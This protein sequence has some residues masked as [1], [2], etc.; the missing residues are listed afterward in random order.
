MIRYADMLKKLGQSAARTPARPRVIKPAAPKPAP[1]PEA[2]LDAGMTLDDRPAVTVAQTPAVEHPQP[3]ADAGGVSDVELGRALSQGRMTPIDTVTEDDPE[4]SPAQPPQDDDIDALFADSPK[5]SSN[6]AAQTIVEPVASLSSEGLAADEPAQD[7]DIDALFADK[8]VEAA[9]EESS[10]TL[11]ETPVPFSEMAEAPNPSPETMGSST[12]T[13]P[14]DEEI[15]ALFSDAPPVV[16]APSTPADTVQAEVP[17]EAPV[18]AP[19]EDTQRQASEAEIDALFSDAPEP[20]TAPAPAAT[21]GKTADNKAARLADHAAST[22]QG[23]ES[24]FAD[25]PAAVQ[26]PAAAPAP[27]A[28]SQPSPSE[29]LSDENLKKKGT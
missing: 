19:V 4:A 8:P 9:P 7:A 26:Q 21:G 6:T 14:S 13:S 22:E 17:A 24:L 16:A 23:I 5:E 12:V 27:E 29:D 25:A 1:V 3:P 2:V 10:K 11:V 20:E 15:D 18:P 28:G